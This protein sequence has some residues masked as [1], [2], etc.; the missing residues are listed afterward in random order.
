MERNQKQPTS[1]I[2]CERRRQAGRG[3][4]LITPYTCIVRGG[5]EGERGAVCWYTVDF[6]DFLRMN[7]IVRAK[8]K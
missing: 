8:K 1:Q 4:L 3:D 6:G 7:R 5:L 2:H